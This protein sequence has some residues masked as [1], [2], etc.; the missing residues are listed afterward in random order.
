MIY[1]YITFNMVLMYWLGWSTGRINLK[2]KMI[3]SEKRPSYSGGWTVEPIEPTL[4]CTSDVIFPPME[5]ERRS[6]HGRKIHNLEETKL[7]DMP[8]PDGDL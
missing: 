3:Q 1:L 6:P 4:A 2:R 8:P 7:L 5:P